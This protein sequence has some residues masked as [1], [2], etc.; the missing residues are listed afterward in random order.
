MEYATL[1]QVLMAI[2]L[3]FVFLTSLS[4][5]QTQDSIQLWKVETQDGNVFV[6][7]ILQQDVSTIRLQTERLGVINIPMADVKNLSKLGAG[8]VRQGRLW[9]ENPQDSRYFWSPSGYGLKK[10]EGYYQNVLVLFNQVA[11][12]ITDNISIG[13]GM[14][15][16]FLFAGT[17][18]PI[19]VTP[20]VSFPVVRD[21]FNIGAGALL[22]VVVG[23]DNAAFGVPYG[24]M[25]F[26][27]RNLNISLGLG[28]G[29]AGSDW[30]DSPAITLSGMFR[31][32]PRSYLI[33]ENLF[34]PGSDL[35]AV[36][37]FGGRTIWS[38]ISLD[39]GLVTP[40]VE[41]TAFFAVPWLGLVV[42]FGRKRV[43]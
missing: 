38:S 16:L 42:P 10:G 18:T 9:G 23:E 20:K 28:Y 24:I 6:G 25:T 26:G 3:A 4:G 41:D 17:S 39:Y 37:S 11:Y 1:R 13:A 19:W 14:V 21:K 35:P 40:I 43:D 15:P 7:N 27:S 22:G 31:I 8:E 30:A 36:L 12:G 33:T 2:C 29:F 32:S 34:L 5:Q